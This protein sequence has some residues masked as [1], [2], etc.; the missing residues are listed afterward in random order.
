MHV[1]N[2][3]FSDFVDSSFLKKNSEIE[4]GKYKILL[5]E[6]FG[7]CGGVIS[8]L[9]K[10]ENTVTQCE[11]INI[12]LLGE[13]IHN[14][15]VNEYFSFRGVKIIP[16]NELDKIFTI[17]RPADIVIIPAFGIPLNIEYKGRKF[18][19]NIVDTTCKNVI[20]VWDFI[21]EE[22]KKSSTIILYGK[23]GHPEVKASTSRAARTNSVIILPDIKAAETFTNFIKNGFPEDLQNNSEFDKYGIHWI[24]K[25]FAPKRFALA[26]QTTMLYNETLKIANMLK[27]AASA[28]GYE[29]SSCNTICRATYLRQKAA[30]KLCDK[31][32]DL[33]FVI[34]GYD[35]SNTNHLFKL[36][37]SKTQA[38]YIKDDK[39]LTSKEITCYNLKAKEEFTVKTEKILKNCMTIGLLAGASCPFS[40]IKKI[41]NKIE[42]I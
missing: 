5:P 30:E 26:N 34:G 10:L 16:E 31:N 35:S 4:K 24:L 15:T 37:D 9:K 22:A 19:H 29:S 3:T 18:F 2:D 33:I 11:G 21:L 8:A 42:K 38:L 23:P 41:I 25:D 17:A 13:I 7:F 40:V 1:N 14:P 27:N 28:A 39:A 36:A 6:V 32:P 12:F 20:D